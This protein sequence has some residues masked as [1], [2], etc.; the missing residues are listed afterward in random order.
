M[1]VRRHTIRAVMAVVA[2]GIAAVLTLGACGGSDETATPASTTPA[3]PPT[4][5]PAVEPESQWDAPGDATL[6]QTR[7]VAKKYATALTAEKLPQAGIYAADAT[8]DYWPEDDHVQGAAE[9]EGVYQ[10]AAEYFDWSKSHVLTAPGVAAYEG[11]LTVTDA[12]TTATV[13]ALALL[14]VDGNKVAHEEVFLDPV[15]AAPGPEWKKA[16]AFCGT[17]PGPKDTAKV[18]AKVA[19]AVGDAFAI[20]D[21]AALQALLA[22][23]V[24]FYDTG[25]RHGVRGIDEVLAWQSQT[26]TLEVA[27]QDP[28]AGRGCAVVRWTIRRIVA[29]TEVAMMP[30]ATVIEVRDGKVVRLTLYYDSSVISLQG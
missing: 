18:A 9:I 13:P 23:N 28:I 8:W 24:L 26:P 4:V 21:R 29:G 30:G 14:A 6:A 19:T 16:V 2:L 11:V 22:K 5:V 1:K 17:M 15:F 27:N 12:G 25:L 7:I 3:A 20:G 10:A